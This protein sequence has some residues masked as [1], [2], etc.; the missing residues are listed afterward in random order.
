M[1]RLLPLAWVVLCVLA[2]LGCGDKGGNAID[3]S[4]FRQLLSAG[5]VTKVVVI[6]KENPVIQG[7]VDRQK[8]DGDS[9]LK[10][11]KE[12][13]KGNKFTTQVG[14]IKTIEEE[15]QKHPEVHYYWQKE[16]D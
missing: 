7:E 12:M 2:P 15:M 8:L 13:I 16:A 14:D 5:V 4:D 9:S 1:R 3:Y 6:G 11:I 10:K